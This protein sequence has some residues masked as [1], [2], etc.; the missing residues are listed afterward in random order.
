MTDYAFA[1]YLADL[2]VDREYQRRGIGRRLIATTQEQ[3][4][5]A[6]IF[7]FAAPRATKYY[8]HLGFDEG[9]GWMLPP[10]GSQ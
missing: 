8:P 7:V 3:G 4:G 2:A 10:R 5:Q 1:T 6:T 9:S